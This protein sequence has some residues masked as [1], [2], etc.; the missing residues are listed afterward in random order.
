MTSLPDEGNML[1]SG[2]QKTSAAAAM[3]VAPD[4]DPI[5]P[6][7]NLSFGSTAASS[8]I[9]MAPGFFEVSASQSSFSEVSPPSSPSPTTTNTLSAHKGGY[10]HHVRNGNIELSTISSENIVSTHGKTFVKTADLAYFSR[11]KKHS[12]VWDNGTQLIEVQSRKKYWMCNNYKL[13]SGHG[14]LAGIN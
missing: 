13:F 1:F 3:V 2:S 4:D 9:P 7:P 5:V 12:K 14:W 11:L 10:K 8:P 6:A